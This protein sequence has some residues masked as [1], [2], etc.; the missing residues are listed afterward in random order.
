MIAVSA[1]ALFVCVTLLLGFVMLETVPSRQKPVVSIPLS[2]LKW[3]VVTIAVLS[4]V[5]VWNIISI[6]SEDLGLWM[7]FKS[8]MFTFQ[9][10]TAYWFTLALCVS[11]VVFLKGVQTLQ[12][13]RR[14]TVWILLFLLIYVQGWGSHASSLTTW[15]GL[16]QSVHLA[17]I[18]AW[19]GPL[20]VVSWFS[21][22][23]KHWDPFLRWFTPMSI[24]CV[25]L[26]I[27]SGFLLMGPIVPEYKN[28]WMLPY[29]QALLIKH[30]LF[31]P[32]LIFAVCNGILYKMN[33]KSSAIYPVPWLRAESVLLLLIFVMSGTLSTSTPPHDVSLT[34][35]E[36][37]VSPLFLVFLDETFDKGLNVLMEWGTTQ[38]IFAGA[39]I[40]FLV[41]VFFSY[42]RRK[43][44]VWGLSLALLAVLSGYF[45]VMT[46]VRLG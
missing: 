5:P 44:V 37:V 46:S 3:L 21:K 32:V 36:A 6:F 30:L 40:L 31:V 42:F 20:L 8:V 41:G 1:A 35:N 28:A 13:N 45:A 11:L 10:G 34:L 25:I 7:T 22:G 18:Y 27:A 26:L 38:Y 33:M 39:S 2:A 23:L 19:V 15:G 4:Y 17:S 9:E 43:K 14:V 12:G 16:V 29:G 24:G